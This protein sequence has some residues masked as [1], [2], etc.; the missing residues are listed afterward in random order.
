MQTIWTLGSTR[1][2]R[3][4]TRR[5]AQH[6]RGRNKRKTNENARQVRQGTQTQRARGAKR[7]S[8]HGYSQQTQNERETHAKSDAPPCEC[9]QLG[10]ELRGDGEN[11]ICVLWGETTT[12]RM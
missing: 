5:G 4:G 9:N 11:E 3:E 1:A 12:G 8:T 2:R 10:F 6:E 7:P